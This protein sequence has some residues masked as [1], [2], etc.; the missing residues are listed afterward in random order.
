MKSDWAHTGQRQKRE[1]QP[2]LDLALQQHHTSTP[3][4]YSDAPDSERPSLHYK[5]AKQE[6]QREES[7]NDYTATATTDLPPSTSPRPSPVRFLSVTS[8]LVTS[9]NIP[10]ERI[11]RV[12]AT[13]KGCGIHF[14]DQQ[15]GGRGHKPRR[16]E[17]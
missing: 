15:H 9:T 4:D 10:E 11:E 1:Q 8:L 7:K 16:E 17:Q 14:Q 3:Q 5:T 2:W 6:L 13:T 12:V